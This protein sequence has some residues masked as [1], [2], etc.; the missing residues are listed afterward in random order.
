MQKL[1]NLDILNA[2]EKSRKMVSCRFKDLFYVWPESSNE[3]HRLD[4]FV[5]CAGILIEKLNP[6]VTIV[7]WLLF[8]PDQKTFI[9]FVDF[10][11]CFWV[12]GITISLA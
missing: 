7:S 1:S 10:I 12:Y 3:D 5:F 2:M 9:S 4:W 6:S 8:D 11:D